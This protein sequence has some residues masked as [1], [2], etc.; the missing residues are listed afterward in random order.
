MIS[1]Y[2]IIPVGL[3]RRETYK[4]LAHTKPFPLVYPDRSA[5]FLRHGREMRQL[6]NMGMYELEN[7]NEGKLWKHKN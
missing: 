6:L 4:E 1:K 7:I 2:G 3:A 5:T